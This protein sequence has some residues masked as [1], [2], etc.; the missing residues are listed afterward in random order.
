MCTQ[1]FKVFIDRNKITGG[2][3]NNAED[4]VVLV[5]IE[6]PNMVC[7]WIEDSNENIL[8]T[9]CREIE[10]G[11]NLDKFYVMASMEHFYSD[12]RPR[13]LTADYDFLMFGRFVGESL[14]Y[15]YP[16]NIG[17]DDNVGAMTPYQQGLMDQ[18]NAEVFIAG[19]D[20]G[21]VS[22]HGPENQYNESRYVDYPLTAFVP[23]ENPFNSRGYIVHI[24]SGRMEWGLRD[25]HLKRFVNTWRS[26]GCD[27]YDNA[28]PEATGW[29]WTW[30]EDAQA[31]EL[32]DDKELSDM[33]EPLPERVCGKFGRPATNATCRQL[34][35]LDSEPTVA[36]DLS[37]SGTS[38]LE[39]WPNPVIGSQL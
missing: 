3:D 15:N 31:F 26:K 35:L 10:Q 7:T 9:N 25:M 32:T 19:Y 24:P 17:F 23:D 6:D 39:V 30:D 8:P 21:N 38:N 27:L 28:D 5:P 4:E 22:H 11:D 34:L 20:G 36:S 18:L 16:T 13:Y 29:K 14:E 2:D 37:E 1:E 33:V 12:G